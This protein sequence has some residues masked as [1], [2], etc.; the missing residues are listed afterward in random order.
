MVRVTFTG[1]LIP[2]FS[3]PAARLAQRTIHHGAAQLASV[4]RSGLGILDR[5]DRGSSG[6]SSF[7]ENRLARGSPRHHRLGR[8]DPARHRLGPTKADAWPSNDAAFDA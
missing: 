1:S 8:L 4:L 7:A 6:S 3:D 2:G 5:L